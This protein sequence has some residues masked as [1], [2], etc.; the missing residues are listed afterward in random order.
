MQ[1]NNGVRP[2]YEWVL[3]DRKNGTGLKSKL[4]FVSVIVLIAFM[5]V[6][7]TTNHTT[8]PPLPTAPVISYL[9]SPTAQ[10]NTS[11]WKT[12]DDSYMSFEYPST[13]KV[14]TQSYT[15]TIEI[16]LVDTTQS[17]SGEGSDINPIVIQYIPDTY[18][19]SYATFKHITAEQAAQIPLTKIGGKDAYV[20]DQAAY[21]TLKERIVFTN[22]K[23]SFI[24]ENVTLPA[25]DMIYQT[26]LSTVSFK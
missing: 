11:T 1:N 4:F 18:G 19:G 25:V 17:Y 24:G 26:I 16:D 12:Y 2:E 8:Q 10:V 22:G 23:V 14:T 3:D 21:P 13:W 7:C 5:A 15:D 6:G 20:I 9:P